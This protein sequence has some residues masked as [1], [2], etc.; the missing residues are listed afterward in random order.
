MYLSYSCSVHDVNRKNS[1]Q[2]P[3]RKQ[4][5]TYQPHC[6]Y[7]KAIK[8]CIVVTWVSCCFLSVLQ[9]KKL[10]KLA[11]G[12]GRIY[13]LD[14]YISVIIGT[15]STITIITTK[16]KQPKS[17]NF[18]NFTIMICMSCCL[19]GSQQRTVLFKT[20]EFW[21]CCGHGASQA[22]DGSRGRQVH[23]LPHGMHIKTETFH[24]L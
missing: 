19:G 13:G 12:E 2:S 23:S 18:P 9:R 4:T 1:T 6:I 17:L 16:W 10:K 20:W 5:W 22:V 14:G 8:S 3:T 21:R 15:I 24:L 11:W 7:S